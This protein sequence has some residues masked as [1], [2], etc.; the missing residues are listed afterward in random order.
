MDSSLWQPQI[1]QMAQ[2][3]LER[4]FPFSSLPLYSWW[5]A[6]DSGVPLH[7]KFIAAMTYK[8]DCMT[9]RQ[10]WPDVSDGKA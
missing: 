2:I 6:Q 3:F 5:C 1:S 8:E 10:H 9:I 4:F 7:F